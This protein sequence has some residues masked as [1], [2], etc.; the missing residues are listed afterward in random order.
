MALKSMGVGAIVE[1][2]FNLPG[3]CFE[4]SVPK[5]TRGIITKLDP[6]GVPY[7]QFEFG[8]RAVMP[9][10]RVRWNWLKILG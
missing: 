5:G 10:Q 3:L 1:T 8:S 4:P 6:D 2:K 9:E 7:V